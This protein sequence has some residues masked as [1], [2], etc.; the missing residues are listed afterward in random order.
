MEEDR[1]GRCCFLKGSDEDSPVPG[2]SVAGRWLSSG[3]T[4]CLRDGSPCRRKTARRSGSHQVRKCRLGR[5]LEETSE[6]SDLKTRAGGSLVVQGRGF[7]TLNTGA[8]VRCPAREL[9][10]KKERKS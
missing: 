2:A 7:G 9:P 6:V 3:T 10:P 1:S 4:R 5:A 8:P